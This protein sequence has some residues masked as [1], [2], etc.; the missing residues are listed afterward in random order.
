[1]GDFTSY[2][3][4][5][6]RRSWHTRA[7]GKSVVFVQQVLPK[8]V[9]RT[10]NSPCT[11]GT[12]D[13][14]LALLLQFNNTTEIKQQQDE[15][16]EGGGRAQIKD[17]KPSWCSS[18]EQYAKARHLIPILGKSNFWR[19]TNK[20]QLKKYQVLPGA[21]LQYFQG[22]PHFCLPYFYMLFSKTL[23]ASCTQ[24]KSISSREM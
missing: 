6:F 17:G 14:F 10:H 9:L 13:Q 18:N 22:I 15:K 5:R 20:K 2:I 4:F 21:F 24:T 8:A 1:M 11:R 7:E 19:K 23:P 3:R 12:K 16:E